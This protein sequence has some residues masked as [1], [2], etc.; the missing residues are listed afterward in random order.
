M[1]GRHVANGRPLGAAAASGATIRHRL[2]RCI[3]QSVTLTSVL[4]A[5]MACGASPAGAQPGDAA[6]GKVVYERRCA[7]CHGVKG[8]GKGPSAELL[9]PHPRDFTTG[10]YKIRTTA[11]RVPSDQDLFRVITN[12]M[13]GTSMPPWQILP[14]RDRWNLVAYIKTF[15]PDKFQEGPKK[16]ELPKEVASSAESIKRGQEMF[17]AIECHKC[18]GLE[19][20]GDGPSRPELKDDA[21]HPIA[22]ANLTKRWTFRGG[23]QPVDIATRLA[24]GVLGTPMPAFLDSVEKPE[25]VWHLTTCIGSLGPA[26]PQYA[27]LVT[28]TSVSE[29]IPDDPGAPFW[30]KIP[31]QSIP[32][33]GQV[34]VDPRNFNPAIDMVTVR[35]AWNDREIAFFLTWDDPNETQG[36]GKQ[37]FS[38]AIS[39]QLP[40]SDAA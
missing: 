5:V 30:A 33:V 3:A 15:A 12:G 22:P 24:N 14:E 20:R 29:A 37:T 38:D 39:L 4:G 11:N 10:I 36:D 32:L 26:T 9:V 31:A 35:G 19:G 28:A 25:D 6:A 40:P 13:P 34:I 2:A 16:L 8:D 7:G 17:E 21:G 23:A 27:T 18:H 1:G